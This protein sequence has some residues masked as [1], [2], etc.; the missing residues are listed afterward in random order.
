MRRIHYVYTGSCSKLRT[1]IIIFIRMNTKLTLSLDEQTI[2]AA[3]AYAQKEQTSLSAIVEAYLKV[4]SRETTS[5]P[6]PPNSLVARFKG[7]TELPADLDYRT[8]HADH[9]EEKYR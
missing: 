8:V 2:R 7:V 1:E 3:K 6:L 5:S 4:V 9:L